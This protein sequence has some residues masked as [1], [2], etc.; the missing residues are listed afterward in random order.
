MKTEQGQIS[1]DL[2][3]LREENRETGRRRQLVFRV[4]LALVSGSVL[5]YIIYSIPCG[6]Y[7]THKIYGADK[8]PMEKQQAYVILLGAGISWFVGG[9][10][11]GWIVEYEVRHRR[12]RFLW[13][14]VASPALP[15]W[16][17][18]L[19]GA[20][21]QGSISGFDSALVSVM[22][23]SAFLGSAAGYWVGYCRRMWWRRKWADTSSDP[24]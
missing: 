15:T 21:I 13:L 12:W 9:F 3:D 23:L 1:S 7:G 8:I 22:V 19:W 24:K 6:L 14:A 18:A 17:F 20:A 5:T 11:S 2:A 10:F 16:L 4:L